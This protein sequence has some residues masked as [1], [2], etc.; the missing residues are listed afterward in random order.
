VNGKLSLAAVVAVGFALRSV[1]A[2]VVCRH[3]P[4]ASDAQD[5]F[6]R[7]VEIAF[8]PASNAPD[9]WPPGWPFVLAAAFRGFGA[10]VWLARVI[11]VVTS[12]AGVLFTSLLARDLANDE[13]AAARAGWIG[14]LYA[15]AVLLVAQT[16][17]QH[18]AAL[19]VA[20]VAYFGARALRHGDLGA[21]IACG[22][23]FGVGALTRPSSLS[24]APVLFVAWALAVGKGAVPRARLFAAGAFIAVCAALCVAPVAL[25]NAKAGAGLTISTNNERNFFLGNNPYTHPYKTGHLGQRSLEQVDAETRAYLESFY[26]RPDARQAMRDEALRYMK[27]HPYVTAYRTLNRATSFWGFDYFATRTLQDDARLP[28]RFALPLLAVEAGSYVAVMALAIIALF[29]MRSACDAWMRAWLVA[30]AL[31][32][33]APYVIAFSGGTY[34][35]P[36]VPLIIPFAAVALDGGL[37]AAAKRAL[38]SRWAIV[39]LVAFALVQLEYAYYAVVMKG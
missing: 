26:T 1:V 35:F 32:Y 38:E 21:A 22:V 9:Y 16:H 30:L 27:E 5:Y 15:P 6:D 4:L 7:A 18:L 34:H 37:R 19:S 28:S 36:V 11:V 23:A 14:A 33:E 25:R 13:R 8:G 17:A 12:T 20:A 2:F 29:A 31:A 3:V 39:A 10:S 24:L